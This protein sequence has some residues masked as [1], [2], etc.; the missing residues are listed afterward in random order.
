MTIRDRDADDE[1]ARRVLFK[2]VPVFDTL[3]RARRSGCRVVW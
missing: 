2:T 3:S 1:D